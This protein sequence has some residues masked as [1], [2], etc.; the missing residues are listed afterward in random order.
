[1]ACLG[2]VAAPARVGAQDPHDPRTI[3]RMISDN[4]RKT[5]YAGRK[6][7]IDFSRRIPEI[8]RYDVFH[9]GADV[10]RKEY[11]QAGK[12]VVKKGGWVW[13]YYRKEGIVVKKRFSSTG[14]EQDVLRKENLDLVRNSYHI[15]LGEG[16]PI[17]G[18][19]CLMV[20]FEPLKD[21]SRPV[22]KVWVDTEKG[23]PLR[24]ETYGIDGNLYLLSHY[25]GISFDPVFGPGTFEVD[26]PSRAKV[27]ESETELTECGASGASPSPARL[28]PWRPE[29]LPPGFVLKC[30]RKTGTAKEP[31]YQQFYSD[32]L[33]A[34]SFQGGG[35]RSLGLHGGMTS[36]VPIGERTGKLYDFGL[37]RLLT[38]K[39][40]REHFALVGELPLEDMTAVARSVRV[41]QYERESDR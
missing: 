5:G 20:R 30:W 26:F 32:G 8:T 6:V 11:P 41:T 4:A 35:E 23:L 15:L 38:W 21:G 31:Q 40:G 34:L 25:E 12:T 9:Q 14:D 10:E 19:P 2:L 22:R 27:V 24:G 28:G 36:D 33:S 17:L 16:M 7:I 3:L 1:M 13:S 18:R 29:N 39:A 37:L